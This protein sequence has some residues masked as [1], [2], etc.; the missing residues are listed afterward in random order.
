MQTLKFKKK[1]VDERNISKI[2]LLNFIRI[3]LENGKES[4]SRIN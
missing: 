4:D 1:N 2:K 3:I